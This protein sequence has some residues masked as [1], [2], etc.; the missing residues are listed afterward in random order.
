ML[1]V[2]FLAFEMGVV[3]CAERS[4]LEALNNLSPVNVSKAEK[5][6]IFVL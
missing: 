2:E 6:S 4:F 1:L 3:G 5:I